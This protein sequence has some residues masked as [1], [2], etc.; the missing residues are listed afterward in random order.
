MESHLRS[1]SA[2]EIFHENSSFYRTLYKSILYSDCLCFRTDNCD[3]KKKN[4]KVTKYLLIP[5]LYDKQQR[6]LTL[7]HIESKCYHQ[8]N[9]LPD[10]GRPFI[11][12]VSILPITV[13][14]LNMQ[15]P[16]PS[17]L[18]KCIGCLVPLLQSC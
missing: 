10:N 2:L 11:A 17:G 12:S 7:T 14:P 16:H 18:T 6:Q 8:Y 4:C 15:G 5:Y 9:H 3:F 13:S 1:G